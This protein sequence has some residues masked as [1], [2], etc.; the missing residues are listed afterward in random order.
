MRLPHCLGMS[1]LI[2]RII[3]KTGR[4]LCLL[5]SR[6]GTTSMFNQQRAALSVK[7]TC[8]DEESL[9]DAEMVHE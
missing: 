1:L 4:M 5:S 9:K 6:R 8:G 2:Y 3:I 7:A